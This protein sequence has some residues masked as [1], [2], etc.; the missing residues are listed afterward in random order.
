MNRRTIEILLL[1]GIVF[2]SLG[3]VIWLARRWLNTA[4][5]DMVNWAEAF[6]GVA[7]GGMAPMYRG[8]YD[9]PRYAKATISQNP[10]P[11]PRYTQA[12]ETITSPKIRYIR[13]E[14]GSDALT[15]SYI[16][17]YRNDGAELSTSSSVSSGGEYNHCRHDWKFGRHWNWG[18]AHY[19]PDWGCDL[20]GNWYVKDGDIRNKDFP[21]CYHSSASPGWME[22]TLNDAYWLDRVVIY[23]RRDWD[24][25]RLGTY[26][27]RLYDN[28]RTLV[29][30]RKLNAEQTQT[31]WTDGYTCRA[32]YRH[33]GG[34]DTNC[35]QNCAANETADNNARICYK[36]CNSTE[37][38]DGGT[39][40]TCKLKRPIG[41]TLSG[42]TYYKD[43]VS[44]DVEL[45]TANCYQPC[46]AGEDDTR[47]PK[48][49]K[50]CPS[51]YR[52]IEDQCFPNDPATYLPIAWIGTVISQADTTRD[53]GLC[54]PFPDKKNGVKAGVWGPISSPA[55]DTSSDQIW[56]Y[57]E[58]MELVN[59]NNRKCLD[60]S[61]L[62][63]TPLMRDCNNGITQKWFIDSENRIRSKQYTDRC[64]TTDVA[65]G[66]TTAA[67][68][69]GGNP[70]VRLITG[71][72][73]DLQPCTADGNKFQRWKLPGPRVGLQGVATTAAAPPALPEP[74]NRDGFI[75]TQAEP[76]GTQAEPIGTQ[77]EP[78]SNTQEAEPLSTTLSQRTTDDAF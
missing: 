50:V 26:T 42:T 10:Y 46:K 48:C 58:N 55:T 6:Q 8:D 32:G 69:T 59:M 62:T 38:L 43:C 28:N 24:T 52:L 78:L 9:R 20:A 56:A 39:G 68:T 44:P 30:E 63:N 61:S 75:G 35:I 1:F 60:T 12:I 64:L 21:Y 71:S 31:Y 76:I 15:L 36:P 53:V 34:R 22:M 47:R 67:L 66:Y 54:L 65:N 51:G 17:V 70:K 57:T 45:D 3:I 41:Y 16:A 33:V 11:Q 29:L 40:G 77:A 25:W 18:G 13:I 7:K 19:D 14:G 72:A 74:I 37:D 27:L 23:N 5:T 4:E 2:V 49:Y 73:T